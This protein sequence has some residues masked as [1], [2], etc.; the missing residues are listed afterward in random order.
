[1]DDATL[2]LAGAGDHRLEDRL[3]EHARRLGV[4]NRVRLLGMCRPQSLPDVYAA[5]NAV[6]FPVRWEEPW[7]VV[8][9]E[10]MGL[11]RPVIA[12]ARGG[13]AEYLRDRGNCL[14]VPVGAPS[15][16]ARAVREL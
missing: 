10:A 5:A 16:I 4:E 13:S 3:R 7:G 14:T 15:A 12:T 6:L 9:L 2:T 8:P 1:A 11:G